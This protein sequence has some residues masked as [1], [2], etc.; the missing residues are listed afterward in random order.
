MTGPMTRGG[1]HMIEA[2]TAAEATERLRAEGLKISPETV[3]H[4][5]QQGVFPFGDCVTED[6]KVKW[7]YIYGSK[8]DAWI[9]DRQK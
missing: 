8:L 7:C 6:G 3:R 9:R 4:G 5:I 2:L 1:E